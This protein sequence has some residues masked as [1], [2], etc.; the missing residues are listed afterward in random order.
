MPS[1][2]TRGDDVGDKDVGFQKE[3]NE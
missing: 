1:G 3:E 2:S